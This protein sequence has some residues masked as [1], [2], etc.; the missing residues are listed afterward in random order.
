MAS[1]RRRK[2]R[3]PVGAAPDVL[4]APAEAQATR[5]RLVEYRA[6]SLDIQ[7]LKP[8]KRGRKILAASLE[9]PKVTWVDIQG[10]GGVEDI[11]K[12]G[13]I[14]GIHPLLL[15]DAVHVPQ[16][17]KS[18]PAEGYL[19][20]VARFESGEP[21]AGDNYTEQVSLFIGSGW[22]VSVQE[23]S[24][25]DVFVP[26]MTRLEDRRSRIRKSNSDYLGYA[27]LD[28][29]IDSHF[30]VLE[31]GLEDIAMRELVAVN[32]TEHGDF[33][34]LQ[35]LRTNAT[36][37]VRLL[38]RQ[39]QAVQSLIR[40]AES[41]SL[42]DAATLIFLRDCLDHSNEQVELAEQLVESIRNL[43]DLHMALLDQRLNEIMRVLTVIA[44][45]FMPLSF[46]AGVYGMNFNTE[47]MP[48]NMPELRSPYGYLIWWGVCGVVTIAMMIW[49]RRKGWLKGSGL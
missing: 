44:T 17:P 28:L 18:E 15:A 26:I 20:V 41:S 12:I 16:L 45:I 19:F 33:P 10:L 31:V 23:R 35:R 3:A 14:F 7:E 24:D 48:L 2:A 42:V 22:V 39:R 11:R 46:F 4:V 1:L 40:T 6:D 34:L 32:E 13:T 27:L 25:P 49:F 43:R 29:V 30:S 8:D 9:G 47:N 5:I 36:A 21:G 38:R 37:R